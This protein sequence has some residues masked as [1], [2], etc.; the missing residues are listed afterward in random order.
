MVC[1]IELKAELEKSLAAGVMT[2]RFAVLAEEIGRGWY[3]KRSCSGWAYA[4]DEVLGGFRVRLMKHWQKIDPERNPYSALTQ[5]MRWAGM[6][7]NRQ[8]RTRQRREELAQ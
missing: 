4:V 3:A 7:F 8:Q 6:D 2:E 1:K 5:Q